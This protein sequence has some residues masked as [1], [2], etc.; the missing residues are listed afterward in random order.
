MAIEETR[1]CSKCHVEKPITEYLYIK[2]KKRYSR[3]CKQCIR[4]VAKKWWLKNLD[5]KRE[6]NNQNYQ[7]NKE[8]R[9]EATRLWKK[10]NP[11]YIANST[12]QYRKDNREKINKKR[13]EHAKIRYENDPNLVLL[14]SLRCRIREVLKA[15][16]AEKSNT[17]Y[18]LIGCNHIELKN[19]FESLFTGGMFWGNYGT[20][21]WSIDHIIPCAS[22]DLTDPEQQKICF[23]YSNLQPLWAEDN[24]KKGA[25]VG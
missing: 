13:R 18:E 15:Q 1:V 2:D 8:R 7:E 11:E 9:K 3:Q 12:R 17:T 16:H 4:D 21:G 23:H 24:R 5:H 14:N 19:H 6:K 22:F 20:H 25:K 10:R